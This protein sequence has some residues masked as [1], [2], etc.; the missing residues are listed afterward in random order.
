MRD[1]NAA[2]GIDYMHSKSVMHRDIK[3]GERLIDR[4]VR[5]CSGHSAAFW[6]AMAG[7]GM[8]WVLSES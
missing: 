7:T 5:N 1:G 3:A 2:G 6:M 4:V 8:N